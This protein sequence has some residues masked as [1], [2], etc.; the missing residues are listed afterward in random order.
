M[1]SKFVVKTWA[2]LLLAGASLTPALAWSQGAAGDVVEAGDASVST[3]GVEPA[4]GAPSFGVT[5]VGAAATPASAP[6]PVAADDAALVA[7]PEGE[8]QE[9]PVV[10]TPVRQRLAAALNPIPLG[11]DHVRVGTYVR[12]AFDSTVNTESNPADYEGFS[13]R[14]A[15][16]FAE[17]DYDVNDMFGVGAK[18]EFDF[19]QG[20]PQ[21][22]DAYASLRFLRDRLQLHVGQLKTAYS[23]SQMMSDT[24]RQFGPEREN[25]T[26]PETLR[27]WRDRGLR[28]DVELPVGDG[29]LIWRTT[30]GNGDGAND[31]RNEDS[32]FVYSTFVDYQPLGEM[33]LEEADLVR[34][35]LLVSFGGSAW[36]TPSI[37]HSE[38]GIIA[39]NTSELRYS[40]HARLKYRGLSLQG[41]YMGV[42]MEG[43]VGS[44]RVLRRGWYA[45]AGYVLPAPIWPQIEIVGRFSQVD[46]DNTRTGFEN[47]TPDFF[48]AKTRHIE[49][50]ANVY[51]VD[52][53]VKLQLTYRHTD[54]L[55]GPSRPATGDRYFGDTITMSLQVGA[56]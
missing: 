34:S 6:A 27:A 4:D 33:P 36:Y 24:R 7:A 31:Y 55:E 51:F 29:Y 40:G 26:S 44:S 8:A 19:R 53:R 52:H 50:G 56:F 13:I 12:A 2:S 22:T 35:P 1:K 17:A 15:R 30:F 47:T 42:E 54:L 11:T 3:S 41:E 18:I 32:R 9:A 37:G 20:N 25:V 45:Q 46:L 16:I 21:T 23:L 43:D 14:N 48:V 10:S 39:P 49:A 28:L 38:F 5:S